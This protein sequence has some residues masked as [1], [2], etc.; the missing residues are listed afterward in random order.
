MDV[1]LIDSCTYDPG[2]LDR[3]KGPDLMQAN[4]LSFQSDPSCL[5]DGSGRAS[6]SLFNCWWS[7]VITVVCHCCTTPHLSESRNGDSIADYCCRLLL[8]I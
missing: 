4:P 7:R 3:G 8:D 1:D 2:L 6:K 5:S